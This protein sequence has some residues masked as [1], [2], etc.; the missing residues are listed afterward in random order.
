MIGEGNQFTEDK[1]RLS[2][3]KRALLDKLL[4]SPQAV[5]LNAHPTIPRR[6]LVASIPLSFSQQQVWAHS[7]MVDDA[8]LYNEQITVYF[9]CALDVPLVERCMV[10]LVRRHEIWRTIFRAV[11]GTAIQIVQPA[12]D[13]FPLECVDLRQHSGNREA[14]ALRLATDDARKRFDLNTGPLLR[15]FAVRIAEAEYRLYVTFHQI[16]FDAFTA[17]RVFVPE[18]SALYSAFSNG[19]ASPLDRP[20]LQYGDFAHWQ[21]N[22]GAPESWSGELSFWRDKLS[23]ELPA[24][25]WPA[26][27]ARVSGGSHC[28]ATER[29]HFE[30]ET[31]RQ[32]RAFCR[33][34]GLSSYM[35]LVASYAALM[36][37]YTG[38]GDIILGGF[39]AGRSHPELESLAG[40]FV[41]PFALRIDLSCNPTFRELAAR[42]KRTVFDAL[43]NQDI[44]FQ[45]VLEELH[46]PLER[47]RNPIF[48]IAISQQPLLGGVA[49]GWNLVSEEVSNGGSKMDLIAVIDERPDGI[50]GPITYNPDLFDRSTITR[51]IE[52]WQT[53]LAGA[54]ANPDSKFADL[55]VMSAAE[56]AQVI[57]QWNHTQADY[58]R[59]L[60]V[61]QLIETQAARTPNAIALKFGDR[62]SPYRD[63]NARAN[64]LARHLRRL[65]VG[66]DVPV[67]VCMERSAEMLVA[68][69]GVM[70]A[71]GA[72]LPLDPSYPRDR[73]AVMLQD[74]NASIVVT[75][76]DADVSWPDLSLQLV[77]MDRDW[78]QISH[79]AA[80]NPGQIGTPDNLLYLIYTS[81]STG[82][83]KGVEVC[84]R[85]FVNLATAVR[86]AP[87]ITE[88]DT[89]L[90]LATISFDIATIELFVPLMVGARVVIAS[91]Q[92]ARDP[93][94]IAECV[95]RERVTILQATPATWRMLL[96][97]GWQGRKDM[98]LISTGEALST[99]LANELLSRGDSLWNMYGPTETTVW[100]TGG[101]VQSGRDPIVIGRPIANTQAYI[102]DRD[103]R[104]MPLGAVGELYIGGDCLARGYL[105]R[106]DL[107]S[108]RLLPSPFIPGA[109]IYKTG[110]LATFRQDGSIECLGRSDRQVKIRGYRIELDEI[111]SALQSNE[112]VRDAAA[113]VR[114]EVPS[115]PRLVAYV[116]LR[117]EGESA[118]A[119]RDSLKSKLPAHMIPEV[120]ILDRLPL[121]PSG[122][123]DRKSLPYSDRDAPEED[124]SSGEPSDAIEKLLAQLWSEALKLERISI[125]DN[126]FD[127]GG[128]SLSAI[129]VLARL[130]DRLGVRLKPTEVAFQSLGQL[131]AVCKERMEAG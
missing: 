21:R 6:P 52:H 124:E 93:R 8:P 16:I 130:Q 22:V 23:G 13:R 79:E 82:K 73:L 58:P 111:E 37:R 55:P 105:N 94:E 25:Q 50:S 64:Q 11:D 18:L 51:M 71:G 99:N 34:E 77:R 128:N 88:R 44:P 65:G 125:Y 9:Q 108:E 35:V 14:E 96:D 57:S 120:A 86:S 74:C 104:P 30:P 106:P 48:Q 19:Q 103:L 36:R 95:E 67:G 1:A 49:P 116:T 127:L 83:P 54:L 17:Y 31:V 84:H 66:P 117:E 45:T 112:S 42:V 26:D 119:I 100:S 131:A 123:L 129:R 56:T 113:I 62:E 10:E 20:A 72:Y 47:G 33:E 27:R 68:L 32:L 102:L 63:L 38:Q 115:D 24:L 89:L 85:S 91:R 60:L 59:D 61:H 101:R 109:R 70:K 4:K 110:D 69:L 5:P 126:F 90:A 81:G 40:Y 80:N 46:I 92:M 114:E 39:S 12:P 98:K 7:Q 118:R 2:E 107:T 78:P 76:S 3:A 122:K 53:L 87:G 29:F 75:D 97:F 41:N 15:A 43:A 121:T 28:G